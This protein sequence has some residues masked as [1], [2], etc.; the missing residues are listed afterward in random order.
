MRLFLPVILFVFIL[1]GCGTL[2]TVSKAAPG[3]P[4][5]YSGTRFDIEAIRGNPYRMSKYR[6]AP[7]EHPALDI[8]LS[9]VADSLLLPLTLPVAAYEVSIGKLEAKLP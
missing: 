5:V 2:K 4:K 9:F 1:G 7:P 8:P 6:V 3:T